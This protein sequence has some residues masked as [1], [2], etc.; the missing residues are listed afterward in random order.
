MACAWLSMGITL[1]LL[2]KS[3]NPFA[4]RLSDAARQDFDLWTILLEGDHFDT[5][6]L[7]PVCMPLPLF[8]PITVPLLPVYW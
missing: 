5:W 8:F 6:R 1:Y 2:H 3:L 4:F 7:N